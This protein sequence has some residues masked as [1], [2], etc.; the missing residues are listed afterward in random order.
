MPL[1]ILASYLYSGEIDMSTKN[2]CKLYP[3]VASYIAIA[4]A[5][6]EI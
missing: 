2:I 5:E 6:T 1:P 4:M 3:L